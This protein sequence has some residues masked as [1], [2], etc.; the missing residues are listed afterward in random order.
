MSIQKDQK[1]AIRILVTGATGYIG[2]RLVPRL[3]EAGYSVKAMSRSLQKLESRVWYNHPNLEVVAGNVLSLDDLENA[4]QDCDIVYY[5]VHSMVAGQKKFDEAEQISAKNMVTATE[6]CG[7]KR[8]VYLGGL[9]VDSPDLSKH[10]RSR[11]QVSAILKTGS[12]PVTVFNA[13]MIIG[14]GSASFEILRYLVDR[15]PIMITPKWVTTPV[16]PIS[17]ANVLE[18]LIQ[19]INIEK[20]IGTTFDIGGSEVLNYIDLMKIY[21]HEAKL[22]K[23][24]IMSVPVLTPRLSSYWIHIVTPVPAYIARPLA[25]GLKNPVIC[26]EN[27]ITKLIPQKLLSCNQA[28]SRA[29]E[30]V[31]EHHIE[32]HWTD[33][34]VFPVEWVQPEDPKWSGGTLFED[35]RELT[36]NSPIEQVWKVVSRVGGNTGWYYG[37]WLWRIR[38]TLDKLIGGVGLRRG[39]RDPNKL[40]LGDAVDFWRVSVVKKE[41]HLALVAEMKLPGKAILEFHLK[42]TENRKTILQQ[43]A[44]FFPK[45]ALGILYWYLSMPFHLFLFPGMIK[46]IAEFAQLLSQKET[47]PPK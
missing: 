21:A 36:I 30:R 16:Q 46:R 38:G 6:R 9:G 4:V 25:E 12:V 34:G 15:L 8:I 22:P 27:S 10:L 42:S 19:C 31:L 2:G 39:R 17:I 40:M 18:Y 24:K 7:V 43:H 37:N 3:L 1:S 5:L 23:R 33:A 44:R 45:G 47:A 28:I 41:S 11:N 13:A 14:S 29:L 32:T 20:T 26:K 35:S